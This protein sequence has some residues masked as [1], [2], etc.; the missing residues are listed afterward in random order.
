[1]DNMFDDIEKDQVSSMVQEALN[2]SD[3]GELFFETTPS[4]S[5]LFD[6]GRLKNA[7]FDINSGF[8]SRLVSGDITGYANSTILS[9]KSIKSS[10]EAIQTARS[11]K[12]ILVS[13]TDH[14]KIKNNKKFEKNLYSKENPLNSISFDEKIELVKNI[15]AFLR[16]YDNRVQQVSVSLAGNFQSIVIFGKEGEIYTDERPLVR[17]NIS[18]IVNNGKRQESGSYGTGGR[19]DYTR[20]NS[21]D[22]YQHAAKKALKQAL[23]NL[24]S[25]D[26]PAGE[27]TVVLASGW[28]GVLLHEAV[29]H[30]LEGDFNRK[31]TSAFSNMLGQKVADE[32]VTVVDN[33]AIPDRRGSLNIDDEGTITQETVLIE[34][35][36]LKGYLQ[37][38]M[39]ARL[40]NDRPTGNGRRENFMY[41]PMPRMTNT[42]MTDG[43]YNPNEIIKSVKKGLYMVNF[44]GGQVDIT[45]GKFVFSCT[46]G[47]QIENGKIC[48]PIKGATLIGDGPK[49]LNKIKMVG[50]D[51]SLDDGIGT[52]GKA[53]QSVPVGVGQPTLRIDEITVGGTS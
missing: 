24:D 19:W 1:M 41:Q 9:K 44:G 22:F 42:Y 50:N 30:G 4:E 14:S 33:G 7:S 48:S 35:G 13:E 46:E 6:D 45:S 51:S 27:M 10:L 2:G 34:N 15:D 49:A 3:D 37:D 21:K 39:N 11:G 38:N 32:Q 43:Q 52:C 8:G 47:Y 36:I 26:T 40:M 18:V 31:G 23:T 28:P 12:E 16:S 5:F 29:G 25:I 53:G 17:L 20:L